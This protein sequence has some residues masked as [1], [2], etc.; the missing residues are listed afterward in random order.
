MILPLLLAAAPDLSTR[1]NACAEMAAQ[2]PERAIEE[3]NAWRL[4]GGGIRARQCLGL[5]YASLQRW[6]PAATAFEQAAR[7][8][9]VSREVDP[10]SLWIQVANARLANQQPALARAALDSALARGDLIGPAQGEARLDRARAGVALGDLK[11]ARVDLDAAL[12]LVPADPLAW[13]LSATLARRQGD[14]ARARTDIDE[15]A[16]RSP[17]DASVALEAGNIAMLSGAPEAARIAWTAAVSAQPG[18]P[19]ATAAAESLKQ[20]DPPAPKG[21]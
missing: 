14:L 12:K 2:A 10:A 11:G 21:P 17:D 13:L 20:L 8:A 18:S 5:A 1:F 4:S 3:A 16:K 15:A 7:E 9:E 6:A 19:A